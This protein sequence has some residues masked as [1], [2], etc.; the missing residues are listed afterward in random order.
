MVFVL[1]GLDGS[2]GTNELELF[3]NVFQSTNILQP[4]P[5]S[6]FKSNFF[7]HLTNDIIS[8]NLLNEAC[9]SRISKNRYPWHSVIYY[10]AV[11]LPNEN[12]FIKL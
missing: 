7:S 5:V 2:A 10:A 3:K 4:N 1:Y 12:L 9:G 11:S 6:I 8:Q